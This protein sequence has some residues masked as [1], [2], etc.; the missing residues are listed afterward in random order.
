MYIQIWYSWGE[1]E[2]AYKVPDHIDA[3][4]F[5]KALAVDE[6]EIAGSDNESEIGLWFEP[7]HNKITLHYFYDDEYC[8]Y[9]VTN[10]EDFDPDM[11]L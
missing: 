9:I 4:E 6:A 3:W 8:Y 5:A 2:P 11:E 7:E 1:Q 10:T